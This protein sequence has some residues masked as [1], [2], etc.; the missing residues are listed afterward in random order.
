M[1]A[2]REIP[3]PHLSADAA[4]IE[5]IIANH[6]PLELTDFTSSLTAMAREHEA[7]L[8]SANP[9]VDVDETRLLIVDIRRGSVVLEL[10]PVLAP[11]ITTAEVT[12]TAIAFVQHLGRAFSILRKPGGRLEDPTVTQLK[13]MSD[14]V[15]VIANDSEGQLKISAKYKNG[16]VIQE[17]IVTK[18]D[19]EKIS[20]NSI[21]QRREIEKRESA[22]LKKVL[23]RLHQTSA[24]N[25]KVD[26]RTSEKGIIERVDGIPRTLVYASDLAGQRIKS[27]ILQADGNPFQ[28]GFIVDADIET[29]NGKPRL[30]RIVEV[31]QIIDLE[32]DDE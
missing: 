8:K 14:A 11:I 23:M 17:F 13:N 19:A 18:S 27:E 7:R 2:H 30:Y 25:L 32:E 29:V 9:K 15:Q 20:Q 16:D 24:E 31:H 12:N 28:K 1:P 6:D 22:E 3:Q 5:I 26:K 21:E 4:R 10:L